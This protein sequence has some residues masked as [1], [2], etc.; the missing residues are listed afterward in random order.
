VSSRDD[1]HRR[2]AARLHAVTVAL[3]AELLAKGGSL[4]WFDLTEAERA[5]ATEKARTFWPE[6]LRAIQVMMTNNVSRS[7]RVGRPPSTDS[8]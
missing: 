8:S 1:R 6:R 3:A 2:A 5:E 4:D 7:R